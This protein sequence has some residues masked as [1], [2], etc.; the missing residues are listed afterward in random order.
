[1]PKQEPV[2]LKPRT[3]WPALEIRQ[4]VGLLAGIKHG[5][6]QT[7]VILG[8][9]STHEAREKAYAD[10]VRAGYSNEW[11]EVQLWSSTSGVYRRRQLRTQENGPV[12]NV[13]G[14]KAG[15]KV[16]KAPAAPV[17]ATAPA[18]DGQDGQK[19]ETPGDKPA[20]PVS[21]T[22]PSSPAQSAPPPAA[23][24]P[25]APAVAKP[26]PKKAQAKSGK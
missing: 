21:Q 25:A 6:K 7:V 24:K 4:R 14:K 10:I 11:S 3:S 5:A 18:Q 22:P 17:P 20:D 15:P 23:A 8:F 9:D 26:Q 13:E 12:I 1:M 19:D 16:G 2:K